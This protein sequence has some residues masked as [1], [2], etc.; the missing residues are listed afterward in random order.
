MLYERGDYV[1]PSDLPHRFLCRVAAVES[2]EVGSG[3]CQLL[4][5]EPLEGPWPRGTRLIR[6][7]SAV[8]PVRLRELWKV[9]VPNPPR[10]MPYQ[11]AGDMACGAAG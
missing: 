10:A 8:L 1:W 7:D 9:P 2:F 4:K 11:A 3:R 5:L 6:L